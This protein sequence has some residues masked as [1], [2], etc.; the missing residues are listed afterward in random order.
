MRH[1]RHEPIL[2]AGL[3]VPFGPPPEAYLYRCPVC[4]EEMLVNEAIIDVAIGTAKLPRGVYRRDAHAGVSR[5]Q[6]R[7]HG[8]RRARVLSGLQKVLSHIIG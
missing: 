7:D 2:Q 1:K 3:D 6:R 4:G 5:M 8:V